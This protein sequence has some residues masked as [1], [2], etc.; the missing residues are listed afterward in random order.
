MCILFIHSENSPPPGRD[1]EPGREGGTWLGMSKCGKIGVLLN[2]LMPTVYPNPSSRGFLVANFLKMPISGG[3]EY[4]TNL[5]NEGKQYTH[6]N[7]IAIDVRQ[8]EI[9]VNHY[10]NAGNQKPE[11]LP[12]GLLGFGNSSLEKPFQKVTEGKKM[13]SK[14]ISNYGTKEYKDVLVDE[15]MAFLKCKTSYYPDH[16][17]L[18]QVPNISDEKHKMH[19]SLYAESLGL[20]YGTRTH[21]VILVDHENQVDFVEWTMEEPINPENPTWMK[22]QT[23]FKLNF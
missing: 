23:S 15:L 18:E 9:K 13:F 12:N 17:I 20:N 16:N 8:T 22:H 11:T 3:F 10:S 7:M 4:L 2:V 21:T 1:M 5:M 19:S 6:F 14:I